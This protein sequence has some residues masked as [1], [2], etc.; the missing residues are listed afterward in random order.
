MEERVAD[1]AFFNQDDVEAGILR[2]DGAGEPGGTGADNQYI[3]EC[4]SKMNVCGMRSAHGIRVGHLGDLRNV[5][6]KCYRECR[7][8]LQE[9]S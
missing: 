8:N 7:V 1:A 2:V 9:C 5:S 4:F 6:E 3:V